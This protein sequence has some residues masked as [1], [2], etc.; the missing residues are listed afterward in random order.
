MKSFHRAVA[1][2]AFL[3]IAA[4]GQADEG[5]GRSAAPDVSSET[6]PPP[7]PLPPET[8]P[9]PSDSGP[10]PILPVPADSPAG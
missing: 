7:V 3:S 4:C 1:L 10:A 6:T 2:T 9:L 8:D 5:D